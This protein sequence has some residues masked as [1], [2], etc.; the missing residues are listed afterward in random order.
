MKYFM[1]TSYAYAFLHDRDQYH[2]AALSVTDLIKPTDLIYTTDLVLYEIASHLSKGEKR[3]RVQQ[4]FDRI[5]NTAQ[6]KTLYVGS[7][8]FDEAY[9]L[10]KKLHHTKAS[11]V[12]CVSFLVMK[13]LEIHYALTA[14]EDFEDDMLGFTATL[15]KV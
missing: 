15:L 11:M 3:I 12:D 14:D 13:E 6:Y 8:Y 4:F 2:G 5:E 10:F 9:E 1:N 7:D